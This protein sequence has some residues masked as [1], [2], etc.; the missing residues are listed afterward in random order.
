[1]TLLCPKHFEYQVIRLF[2]EMK[3]VT[4]LKNKLWRKKNLAISILKQ[5]IFKLSKIHT[6][7][8]VS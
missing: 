2:S 6:C 4:Y 1:M 7:I 5:D 3:H 8:K